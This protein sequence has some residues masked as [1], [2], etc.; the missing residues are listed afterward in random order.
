M[1]ANAE[2]YLVEERAGLFV[3]E[4]PRGQL[5]Y[6]AHP[7]R[8][9]CARDP[10]HVAA[11]LLHDEQRQL[12]LGEHRAHRSKVG[13]LQRE[14]VALARRRTGRRR[15]VSKPSESTSTS[16]LSGRQLS[17]SRGSGSRRCRRRE[18]GPRRAWRDVRVVVLGVD[19]GMWTQTRPGS[20]GWPRR[21]PHDSRRRRGR[22]GGGGLQLA[23]AQHRM[24]D[25][26]VAT[27]LRSGR[28]R[29][30]G[31]GGSS[32]RTRRRSPWPRRDFPSPP[33]YPL[34]G[35][36][37]ALAAVLARAGVEQLHSAQT[38]GGGVGERT[39]QWRCRGRRRSIGV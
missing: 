7:K 34:A 6:G 33:R 12:R 4:D 11:A 10:L 5:V 13:R 31:P 16:Q 20:A 2:S 3:T 21:R 15:R 19:G 26:A 36:A 14:P 38:H 23:E 39:G 28:A 17:A 1:V 22:A 35:I 32:A 24:V 29:R 27:E 18:D 30:G 25:E 37:R 8:R 9:G